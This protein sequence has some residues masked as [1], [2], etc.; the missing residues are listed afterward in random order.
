MP[1][2]FGS[3]NMEP[4]V[5]NLPLFI[6]P[7]VSY[8]KILIST[9]QT[10]IAIGE[11]YIKQTF[12][13]RFQIAGPNNLQQLSIPVIHPDKNSM[14]A[15]VVLDYNQNWNIKHWRSIETAYRK[16]P[17]FEFYAHYFEPLFTYKYYLLS[18]M[19]IESLKIILKILKSETKLVLQPDFCK[20]IDLKLK[21][22][23]QPY[24]Q[25]FGERHGFLPNLSVLDLIFN[26]GPSAANYI[27]GV[28]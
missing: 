4:S 21:D 3:E 27:K 25:V 2:S 1:R 8:V 7:P 20:T 14:M 16:A 6:L 26:E 11:K 24:F 17:F 15:E 18:E 12:R 13:T 10:T 19:N 22:N 5:N 23:I 9:P 28:L